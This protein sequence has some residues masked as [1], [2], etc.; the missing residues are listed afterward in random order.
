MVNNL[1]LVLCWYFK[2]NINKTIDITLTS[3]YYVFIQQL[4]H[5]VLSWDDFLQPFSTGLWLT[6]C[7]SVLVLA[8]LLSTLHNLGRRCGN[9]EADG[10]SRYS[11][12]DSLHCVFGI[13][14]QQGKRVHN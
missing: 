8:F 13:F 5:D 7:A 11:L 14:C 6:V 10:P 1:I 12:Y 4:S 9:A 2:I 3:R